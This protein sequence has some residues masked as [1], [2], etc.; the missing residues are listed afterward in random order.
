MGIGGG[1]LNTQICGEN[2]GK[3]ALERGIAKLSLFSN[4]QI[5][6][7]VLT[8]PRLILCA[9]S[10]FSRISVHTNARETGFYIPP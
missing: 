9:S 6:V 7:R 10:R 3:E 8:Q 2:N 5:E 1:D 4:R